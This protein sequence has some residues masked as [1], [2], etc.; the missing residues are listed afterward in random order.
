[1]RTGCLSQGQID[2]ISR[3]IGGQITKAA[4]SRLDYL[5]RGQ[6]EVSRGKDQSRSYRTTLARQMELRSKSDH[7]WDGISVEVRSRS[8]EAKIEPHKT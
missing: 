7:L 4:R 1:M 2:T 3:Y 6:I 8:V 5:S